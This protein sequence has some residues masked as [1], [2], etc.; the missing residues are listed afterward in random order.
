MASMVGIDLGCSIDMV[1][2]NLE[3]MRNLEQA[4]QDMMRQNL[5]DSVQEMTHSSPVH[6]DTGDA[7]LEEFCSD[8]ESENFDNTEVCF[9]DLRQIFSA[10]KNG[11]IAHLL[12]AV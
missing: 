11:L 5:N 12:W 8:T 1:D 3:I 9:D 2:N 4:R 10:K 6:I 7:D